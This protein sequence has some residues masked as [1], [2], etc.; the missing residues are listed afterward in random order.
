MCGWLEMPGGGPLALTVVDML[1]ELSRKLA[2]MHQS[3]FLHLDLKPDNMLLKAENGELVAM[4]SDL[5]LTERM[6]SGASSLTIRSGR[7]TLGY[8][9]EELS[10]Q[11]S[12]RGKRITVTKAADVYAFARSA[13]ETMYGKLFLQKPFYSDVQCVPLWAECHVMAH[14]RRA[15]F[16]ALCTLQHSTST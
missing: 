7:G 5:G 11:G 13:A 15:T 8:M 3:G 12:A 9:A 16:A 10:A 1:C 2:S 14:V 4:I 6:K